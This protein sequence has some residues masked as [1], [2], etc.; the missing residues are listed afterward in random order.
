MDVAGRC[1]LGC[2]ALL[3]AVSGVDAADVPTPVAKPAATATARAVPHKPA[4]PPA[5]P[6]VAPPLDL[7]SGNLL[8]YF[9]A[10]ELETPLDER[11]EEIIVNGQRLEA[12]RGRD[13]VPQGVFP[14][15]FYAGRYPLDAWRILTPVPNAVI[16]DRNVDDPRDPPGSFRGQI[17]EP[18]QIYD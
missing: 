8:D 18:G 14:S 4:A 13:Q 7:R 5:S 9:P 6:R 2:F 10:D 1:H 16:P 15:L 3:L 11:L 12:L 17:L